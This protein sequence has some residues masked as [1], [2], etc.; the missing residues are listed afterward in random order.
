MIWILHGSDV[1]LIYG[2]NEALVCNWLDHRVWDARWKISYILHLADIS[3]VL[4]DTGV[5]TISRQS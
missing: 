4:K 1:S 3:L 2:R 5:L